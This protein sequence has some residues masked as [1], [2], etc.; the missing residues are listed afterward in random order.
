MNNKERGSEKAK[1]KYREK[2]L[3][4]K[5]DRRTDKRKTGDLG[6][7]A[8]CKFLTKKGYVVVERNYLKKYGE[9]DIVAMKGNTCHFF[10]VKTVSAPSVS[11]SVSVVSV[12]GNN[13]VIHETFDRYRPED[14][15]HPWKIKRL[16]RV[17]Q[18]YLFS[19]KIFNSDWQFNVIT[20]YLNF[21]IRRAR[22][23][24]LENIVL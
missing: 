11:P 1:E 3:Q 13:D 5:T 15:V 20:V 10:E 18:T 16:G 22:I 4:P 17:I 14:N 12:S 9:I 7:E 2:C 24:L 21:R 8:A 6:E 23:C 19:K